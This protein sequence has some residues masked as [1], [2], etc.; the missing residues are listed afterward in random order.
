VDSQSF[1]TG[2]VDIATLGYPAVREAFNETLQRCVDKLSNADLR[3]AH[4]VLGPEAP[5]S[6][7]YNAGAMFA[8]TALYSRAGS[9]KSRRAIDRIAPKLRL[10]R[11]PLKAAIAARLPSA[12]F[13]MLAIDETHADGG[14]LARDLL[15]NRRVIHV[16]DQALA[17]QVAENGEILLAGRFVDLGPWHVGFGLVLEVSKSE[18]LAICLALSHGGTLEERRGTLHELVYPARLLDENLVMT[19]LEPLIMALALA[20]DMDVI[21]SEDFAARLLSILPGRLGAA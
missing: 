3:R 15:D 19:A 2:G 8:D 13:T 14:V 9:P 17:A 11:S 16:M 12:F 18:A 7:P 4:E 20:I 1:R 5:D 6:G 21:D 10:K